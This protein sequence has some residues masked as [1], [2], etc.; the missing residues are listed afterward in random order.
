CFESMSGFSTTGLTLVKDLDHLSLTH[1][2]WRHLS[3]F[4]G[5]QGIVVIALS[6]FMIK[7]SAGAFRIYASE[8]RDERVL[9][10]VIS[11]ARFIWLVS[12][13]YL[14]LGTLVLGTVGFLEGLS[15]KRAFFDGACIFMAAFDT[16]GFTPRSQNMLYYH[17][18]LLE[19]VTVSL[20]ILGAINFNLHYHIWTGNR[21][22]VFKN[23]EMRTLGITLLITFAIIV[24]DLL[25]LNLYPQSIPFFRK[26]F[27]QL[28]S[29]H[30]GTGYSNLYSM[31]FVREWGNLS[32]VGII[33]AMGLGGSICSTTGGI[34]ALRV[35]VIFKSLIQDVKQ[36]M[37]PE[38]TVLQQK[39]HHLKMIVLEDKHVRAAV[40]TVLLY[41]TLYSA[42][43][44]CGM[45]FGYPFL[46]SL[47]ES[48][49]AAANVGLSIGITTVTMPSALKVIYILQ[50]WA[51][52]LEFISIFVLLGF[53]VA[54]FKGKK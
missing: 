31:Q 26:G 40:V 29:A 48:T 54:A 35:G 8:A 17:S 3:M 37:L 24:V 32:L 18:F 16:G 15:L 50:M 33:M 9:P 28:I 52:R 20:M 25:R 12:I 23:I 13:V 1:N 2:F 34:K 46:E 39:F 10:N 41:F 51:G 7:G 22:E 42:G 49:S 5:G 30:T 4:V 44:I 21:K 19:T 38:S 6:V 11:T 27:Y 45:F 47:F 14:V 36:I 43:A 53:I